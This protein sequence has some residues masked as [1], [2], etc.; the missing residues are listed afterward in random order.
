M[1]T[2]FVSAITQLCNEKGVPRGVVMEAIEAALVSAY[3]RN[4]DKPNHDLSAKI[5]ESS[6]EVHIFW[7][8]KVTSIEP[9]PPPEPPS[10]TESVESVA[11]EVSGAALE[12]TELVFETI[13]VEEAQK[14]DSKLG[15]GDTL[16]VDVTPGQFGRIA[17]QTAK[18][19]VMQK[20]REAERKMVYDEFQEREGEIVHGV[21]QRL[22]QGNVIVELGRAE[23][24]M[25][26]SEQVPSER[27]YPGQRL[28]VYVSEVNETYRGPQIIVSR[29]HRLMLRRL[30]EQE[31]P[32][33]YSGTVEIKAIAREGGARS[34]VAVLAHQPGIDPVG[35]CVGMRGVRIQNIVNEL[36][37]EKIDVVEWDEDVK[38]YVANA[39]SPAQVSSVDTN[40]EEKTATV[41]VPERQLSLAIGKEGQNARLAAKLTGWRIDIKSD[42]QA[43][44]ELAGTSADA[45]SPPANEAT[46]TA[47][48][49]AS[50]TPASSETPTS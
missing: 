42:I 27:Y 2:E 30:L 20:L 6:G 37:G 18:Q 31:V 25:P 16:T 48:S 34:K 9:P 19:V 43:A 36:N 13:T 29:G 26:R 39:L 11:G 24:V 50:G 38:K 44:E 23:A 45:V 46:T 28:R 4:F 47:E 40:E 35:S 1:K 14:I 33:I 32:E 17:A 3:R 10:A 22:E 5:D 41:V 8:R 12:P 7:H 15:E 49:V 21:V